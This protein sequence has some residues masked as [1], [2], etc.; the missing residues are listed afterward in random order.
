MGSRPTIREKIINSIQFNS[1]QS[2][3]AAVCGIIISIIAV[4]SRPKKMDTDINF[5]LKERKWFGKCWAWQE[6][7]NSLFNNESAFIDIHV[8]KFVSFS[9]PVDEY[10]AQPFFFCALHKLEHYRHLC[11]VLGVLRFI[12]EIVISADV[13]YHFVYYQ[14][15]DTHANVV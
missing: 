6:C 10:S 12:H 15:R 8:I 3:A 4:T 2:A 9:F 11:N 1:L 7:D 5:Y 14:R 13:H